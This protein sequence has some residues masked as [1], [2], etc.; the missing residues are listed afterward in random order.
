MDR[1]ECVVITSKLLSLAPQVADLREL[2]YQVS[3]SPQWHTDFEKRAEVL[4]K[5]IHRICT[6]SD[7]LTSIVIR[8]MCAQRSSSLFPMG[9]LDIPILRKPPKN[10][11]HVVKN[12]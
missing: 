5:W 11:V 2:G 7:G 3:V 9:P 8:A 10:Y 4:L 6:T 12:I 1:G